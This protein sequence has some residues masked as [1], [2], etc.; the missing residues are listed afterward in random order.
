MGINI[1]GERLLQL[2]PSVT[3]KIKSRTRWSWRG[4]LALVSRKL[5]PRRDDEVEL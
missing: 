3:K 4:W 2:H 5:Y 1:S